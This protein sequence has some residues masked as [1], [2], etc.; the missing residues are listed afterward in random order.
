M[1]SRS[2]GVL[3][4]CSKRMPNRI[5]FYNNDAINVLLPFLKTEVTLYATKSLFC[6]AYLIDES[7]NHLIMTDT[8]NYSPE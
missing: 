1:L 6:L 8:G 2:L 3:H 7:N 5:I 4:N